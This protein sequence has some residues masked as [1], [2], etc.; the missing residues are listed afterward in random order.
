MRIRPASLGVAL[1]VAAPCALSAQVATLAGALRALGDKHPLTCVRVALE[2]S[3]GHDLVWTV[4]DDRALFTISVP[5]AGVY[6]LRFGQWPS[7]YTGF[8]TVHAGD[9]EERLYAVPDEPEDGGWTRHDWPGTDATPVAGMPTPRYPESERL[10]NRQG[11]VLV[12]FVIDSAGRVDPAG[13]RVLRTSDAPFAEAVLDVIP[14]LRYYPATLRG[15]AVCE[16][17]WQPFAFALDQ[18]P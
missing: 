4:T 3:A 9:Y 1:L 13:A 8:D 6:R 16:R 12:E 7:A 11:S 14:Q 5:T 17:V 15:T 10:A 18:A 2:D